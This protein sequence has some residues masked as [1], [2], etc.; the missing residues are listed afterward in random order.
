LTDAELGAMRMPAL[1]L[2]TGLDSWHAGPTVGMARALAARIPA[3]SLSV[4]DGYGTFFFIERPELFGECAGRFLRRMAGVD[5]T[6][7]A[8]A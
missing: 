1:I 2:A 6:P 8:G 5:D 7:P 3:S 4:I